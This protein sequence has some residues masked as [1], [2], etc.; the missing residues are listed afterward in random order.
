[1]LIIV[2]RYDARLLYYHQYSL[3]NNSYRANTIQHDLARLGW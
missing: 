3:L 1:M 2:P